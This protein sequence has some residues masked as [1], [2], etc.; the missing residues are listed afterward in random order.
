VSATDTNASRVGL[1]PGTFIVTRSGSTALAL[2]VGYALGGTAVNGTDYNPLATSVAISAGAASAALTVTPKSSTS[3]VGAET[4]NLTLSANAAYTVGSPNNATITI[5]GNSVPSTA[6]KSGNNM[7]ITWASTV[8]KTYRVAYKNGLVD[9][10]WTNLSPTITATGT[11]TSYTD[12][13]IG[14]NKQRY[15][16]VYLLN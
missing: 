9:A 12:T 14:A 16:M 3:L 10:N 1:D 13:T 6:S 15:Y 8:G 7:R 2:T 5:A 11:S 4:V